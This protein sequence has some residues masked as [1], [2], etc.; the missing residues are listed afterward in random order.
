MIQS[1]TTF[2]LLFLLIQ[3][4]SSENLNGIFIIDSCKCNSSIETCEAKGPFQFDQKRS[5]ISIRYGST[6]IGVGSLGKNQV[7]LYLNQSRCKGL[8]NG[9]LHLAELICQQQGGVFC[10]TNL[11]CISGTC[12]NET[13]T[14]SSSVSINSTISFLFMIC[15][16][17]MLV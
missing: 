5:T 13:L 12:L 6:Q 14:I 3:T 2:V 4:I 16:L 10:T 8:W 11:R 17:I 15:V 1:L 9:K 7:D